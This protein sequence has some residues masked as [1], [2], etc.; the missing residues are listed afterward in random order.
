MNGILCINKP[1]EYT[2]FDVVARIRG[3]SKTK[4]VGHSGTLDPLATGVLPIFIG[5]ATK[6]CD[7]LP[8]DDKS[9][10]AEFQLGVKT[11]TLD[12]SGDVVSTTKSEINKKQILDSLEQFRGDIQQIPPMYSAVRINGQ[13]LYDLAR[14]GKEV[15]REPKNVTILKLELLGFDEKTQTGKLEISC[16]K[17]TYIRTIISDMGDK[18]GVGGI[19]TTLCRTVACGFPLSDCITL[20][21]AQEKTQNGTLENS[22]MSVDKMFTHLPEINLNETQS[23]KFVNGVKLDLGRVIYADID[24]NHR[25][26]NSNKQFIGIASL[27]KEKMVLVIEKMFAI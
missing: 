27:D 22:L 19:M 2:S 4:R 26:Y 12:I 5:N 16:S 8:N 1:E 10:I 18:L 9:Y 15:E 17:G 11:D 6:A 14:Q 25:V 24:T 21:Q 13:R 7:M 23:S 3:M 20:E